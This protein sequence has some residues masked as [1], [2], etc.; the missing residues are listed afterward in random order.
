MTLLGK[1]LV[2]INLLLSVLMLSVAFAI[3]TNHIDFSAAAPKGDKP[4]G[5]LKQRQDRV[6]AANDALNLAGDR[7]RDSL[8]GPPSLPAWEKRLA[9]DRV[10]YAAQLEETQSGPEGKLNAPIKAV[11]TGP[12]GLPI[13][14]PANGGRPTMVGAE[15]RRSDKPDEAPKPLFCRKW[16]EQEMGRLS[17]AI[18]QEQTN[19]QEQVKLAA[20]LTQQAIG[21]KGLRQRIID[22]QTKLAR[23][24]EEMK[25]VTGR[26]KNADVEA[27]LLQ[28]RHDQL[29]RRVDE[30]KKEKK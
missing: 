3:Y 7:W 13:P 12:D 11:K 19:Y 30:L 28:S 14:D 17:L 2:F 9:D 23:I 21:P 20:D 22:E 6:K 25:D 24:T 15:R 16:Y 27:E 29:E 5:L 26:E 1:I 8:N 18:D 4:A 10:W